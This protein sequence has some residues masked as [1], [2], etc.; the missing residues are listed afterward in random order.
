M[1]GLFAVHAPGFTTLQAASPTGATRGGQGVHLTIV[2]NA[3]PQKNWPAFKPASFSVPAGQLVT[4]IV[5]NLDAATPLPASSGADAR[6]TG[7]VGN[8]EKVVPIRSEPPYAARG[9]ARLTR[10]VELNKVSHTFSIPS[11]RLNVPITANSRT[12][13]TVRIRKVGKYSW[14]CF[15]PC[16][17]GSSGF[18]A[19]MG[20]IGYMAGTVT[21]A[22]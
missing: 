1:A 18:A 14:L 7:V 4:I 13:F 16:G 5:T 10:S 3:G 17:G 12:S 2:T 22:A 8:V 19:P 21:A 9:R 6:V 11:L 20:V 15:D